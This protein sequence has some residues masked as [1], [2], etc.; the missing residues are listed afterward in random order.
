[1]QFYHFQILEST[2]FDAEA[3]QRPY[4]VEAVFSGSTRIDVQQVQ[5]GVELDFQ[6]V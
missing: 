3:Y 6:D 2:L 4:L 1:M 5:P